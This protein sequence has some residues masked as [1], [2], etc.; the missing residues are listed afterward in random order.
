[1]LKFESDKTYQIPYSASSRWHFKIGA[2]RLP[3]CLLYNELVTSIDNEISKSKLILER[4]ERRNKR[5][6]RHYT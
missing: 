5:K 3:D 2:T 4:K 6:T 1:M